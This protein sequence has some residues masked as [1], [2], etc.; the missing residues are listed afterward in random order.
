M[1]HVSFPIRIDGRG[2]TATVSYEQHVENM[3]EQLL[4]TNAGERVNRPDFGGGLLQMVFAPG[5]DELAAATQFMVAGAI[6]QWLGDLLQVQSVDATQTD[7]TLS[8]TV[9]Y[10]LRRTQQTQTSTFTRNV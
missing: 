7:S 5:S 1:Q 10:T 3:L 2:R 4:F 9:V 8:V 6:Q